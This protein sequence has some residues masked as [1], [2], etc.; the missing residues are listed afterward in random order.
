M[1]RKFFNLALILTAA[2]TAVGTAY[3][4]PSFADEGKPQG[5]YLGV[6]LK[7]IKGEDREALNIKAK[8]GVLIED[9]VPNGPA[10]TA[11]LKPGDVIIELDGKKIKSVENIHEVL[12]KAK[13]DQTVAVVVNREGKKEKIKLILGA[14]PDKPTVIMA[15]KGCEECGGCGEKC[16]FL[17]V[18]TQSLKDQLAGYFKVKSGALI[19]KVRS[20]MPAEAAG[21]KAGDVIVSV[22]DESVESTEQLGK[23]VRS[24]K[25]EEEVTVKYVREGSPGEVK[26]KLTE[27]P[28][29]TIRENDDDDIELFQEGDFRLENLDEL[30]KN[31]NIKIH[32]ELNSEEFKQQVEELR[33]EMKELRKEIQEELKALKEKKKD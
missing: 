26:V 20:E 28:S 19:T 12:A 14:K 18:E 2:L 33:Q 22:N 9:L 11:G 29:L 23:V 27:A 13:P 3:P 25:P 21:L 8:Q 10:Q 15:K 5:A 4:I 17:G 6:Y 32:K 24:H 30:F 7:E 1:S 31:I 16:G